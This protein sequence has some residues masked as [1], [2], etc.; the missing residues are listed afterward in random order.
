[1]YDILKKKPHIILILA[2]K[3]GICEDGWVRFQ[4]PT[5][6]IVCVLVMKEPQ[7]WKSAMEFCE[8]RLGKLMMLDYFGE[9]SY[10]KFTEERSISVGEEMVTT[11]K[12]FRY[13]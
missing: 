13:H 3:S 8:R 9:L 6:N 7:V 10:F 4:D 2:Q 12:C 1:M 5:Q 11:C